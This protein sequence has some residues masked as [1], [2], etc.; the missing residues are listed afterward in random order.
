MMT[1]IQNK[2]LKVSVIMAVYNADDTLN[3]AIDSILQQTF[4][5]W[6]F[7]ICDDCSTDGTAKILN[8]YKEAYPDK[9]VLLKNEKNSKLAYSLNHCLRYAQGE[10]IARMDADDI[11]LEQRFEK[12]VD[13]LDHNPGYEL[14][15]TAMIPFDQKGERSPRMKKEIPEKRDL[16]LAPIFNHA[17]IMMRKTAYTALEGYNTNIIRTQDYELWFRFFKAGFRG[18][19][20]QDAYYKVREG[21]Q[22]YNRRT[23]KMRIQAVKIRWNGYRLLN[24]PPHLYLFALKPLFV[25][26]VPKKLLFFIKK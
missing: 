13:F 10:Y 11:S 7:V 24:F 9:F 14:V 17:T 3:E 1:I 4:T 21:L 2:S 25:G 19:N 23:F 26:L 16:L 15:G 12:Q 6:E 5:D 20:M 22:D 8:K 18:Y